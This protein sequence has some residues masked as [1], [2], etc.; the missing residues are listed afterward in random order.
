[1]LA[2]ERRDYR[3]RLHAAH[4]LAFFLC[5]ALA[6]MLFFALVV[7]VGNQIAGT[8][9]QLPVSLLL[10]ALFAMMGSGIVALWLRML[11]DCWDGRLRSRLFLLPLAIYLER[12]ASIASR[13]ISSATRARRNGTSVDA[14][15]R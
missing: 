4:A 15:R 13:W 9:A 3:V 11:A 2:R 12:L 10:W 6:Q 7:I 8:L 14:A 5:V 1:M